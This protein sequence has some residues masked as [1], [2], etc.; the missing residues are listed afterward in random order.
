MLEFSELQAFGRGRCPFSN[1]LSLFKGLC[2][3]VSQGLVPHG[4]RP[5]SLK[6]QVEGSYLAYSYEL[7]LAP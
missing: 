1:L 4:D 5:G 6:H 3:S 7:S 2:A